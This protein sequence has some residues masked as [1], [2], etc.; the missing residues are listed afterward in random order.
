[1]KQL[2]EKITESELLVLKLFW[3]KAR[4]MTIPELAVE[5]SAINSW[6]RSTI[7]T[8]VRRLHGKGALACEQRDVQY[9]YPLITEH[10]YSEYQTSK[11]LNAFYDGKAGN[12]IASLYA[13]RQLSPGEISKLRQMLDAGEQHA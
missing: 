6:D 1:M 10:E 12:L 3:T 7:K 5:L 11:L 2:P 8:L 13:Q 4:A 9:F